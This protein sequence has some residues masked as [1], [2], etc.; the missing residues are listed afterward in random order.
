MSRKTIPT[1]AF[2]T[3]PTTGATRLVGSVL[4]AQSGFF[5]VQTEQGILECRLRGR[6]KKERQATDLVVIGDQV[7]VQPVG[8]GQG[9]IEAVLPRRSRL[10]RRAAGSRGAY[11]EDVIVANV[12][13]V[14]LV[15]ACA[16]PDFTPRM[17]DRYLVIC[18]HSGLPVVIVATKIDL[19]ERST[20]EAMF[21][22]YAHIGYPIVYTSIITG[23][24]IDEL[25]SR[26]AGQI[27]VVTG[28][29]GV[30]KSS[31]LNAIQPGL[32][33]RTGE[34]S[35]RLSKG[36]HTTTVAELIPLNLPGGGYVADTPGIR[37]I[38]LWNLPASDLAWCF[39]EFRPFLGDCYFVGCTHLHEPRCAVRA[40]VERGEITP[41]RYES[42][43]RLMNSDEDA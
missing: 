37:E 26:L 3:T 39:R 21:A 20:A 12:D 36:R 9:A 24:G 23:E 16:Q 2:E 41:A 6:L 31:L 18:E 17:L 33:L 22:P 30:G 14:L 10:A 11:K 13:Q 19:V 35:E 29:S 15:F 40:A 27:S 43:A 4:R 25:R 7:E 42:Y 38:G 28:K 8:N 34:V 1:T 32:N 5:W